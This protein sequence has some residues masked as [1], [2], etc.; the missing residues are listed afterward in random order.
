MRT[1]TL[2]AGF[3]AILIAGQ[4][5]AEDVRI[6]ASSPEA[7]RASMAQAS[8]AQKN[9]AM[10]AMMTFNAKKHF[11]DLPKE[12]AIMQYMLS[13]Q[14]EAQMVEDAR[15]ELDLSLIHI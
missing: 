14:T 8:E 6:D 11:P 4:A 5:R 9:C 3:F 15:A 7:M 13:D 10:R 1:M 12:S 2:A